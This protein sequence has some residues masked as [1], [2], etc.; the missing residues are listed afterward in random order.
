MKKERFVLLQC[1]LPLA[2][3]LS[4]AE[5]EKEDLSLFCSHFVFCDRSLEENGLEE[6]IRVEHRMVS[7]VWANSC[8]FFVTDRQIRCRAL[9]Q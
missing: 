4:S 8:L 6:L 2:C 3:L 7:A 9:T 5:H 1:L